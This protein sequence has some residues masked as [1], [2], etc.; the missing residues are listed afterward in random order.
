MITA[1]LA[2]ENGRDV[3]VLPGNVTSKLSEG[4]NLSL[5]HIF[6]ILTDDSVN[7]QRRYDK[8]AGSKN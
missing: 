3:F 4:T 8:H 2:L 1:D 5:I 6:K 7:I